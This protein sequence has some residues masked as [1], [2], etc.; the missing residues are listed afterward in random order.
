MFGKKKD[1]IDGRRISPGSSR[2]PEN[3]SSSNGPAY[4][5]ERYAAYY[6][7]NH[8]RRGMALIF[9]HYNFAVPHMNFPPREG[10]RVDCD[11]L[12]E[13]LQ[14]FGFDVHIYCDYKLAEIKDV[15][16][17][18]AQM[19]HSDNDCLLVAVLTHG[20]KGDYLFAYDCVYEFSAIWSQ[21]TADQCRTLAGRPKIFLIQACRGDELQSG[22]KVQRDGI[23][24]YSIPTHADFLFAYATIPGY[25]AFRN[26]THGSWFINE[27]CKEMREN[28][29][30]Y[31]FLTLLTFVSQKVAFEHESVSND[32]RFNMRKQMPCIVS[33]L[34]RV[35]L[36]NS[37]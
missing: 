9:S 1:T 18:V 17:K 35:L 26:T 31:D 15:T 4:I 23:A 37:V 27:L 13:M 36:F 25:M 14:K 5:I 6:P 24:R 34:T 19:D 12:T 32:A 21:F 3:G 10:N 7:M 11:Q 29:H 2:S 20:E 33:M 30:K 28:G 16:S 8:K 22:V